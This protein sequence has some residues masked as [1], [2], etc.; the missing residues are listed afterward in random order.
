MR[1]RRSAVALLLSQ[2]QPLLRRTVAAFVASLGLAGC[3]DPTSLALSGVSVISFTQT[4]KTVTDHAM[5]LATSQ[6][7]SL[8]HSLVGEPWCQPDAAPAPTTA[9][10]AEPLYCY[11]SIAAV[12]CYRH[13]NPHDTTTRR[14]SGP[15][16][17]SD[18]PPTP[19]V[20]AR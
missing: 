8:K 13:D 4:G 7:C 15:D 19:E 12:T 6:N 10:T 3:A 16:Q 2:R 1:L 17:P 20:A 11:R 5:S 14:T 9:S 18:A